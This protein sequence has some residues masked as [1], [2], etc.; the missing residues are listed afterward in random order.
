MNVSSENVEVLLSVVHSVNSLP[1]E[2]VKLVKSNSVEMVCVVCQELG[3]SVFGKTDEVT[4]EPCVFT[5]LRVPVV[6]VEI[7]VLVIGAVEMVCPVMVEVS[8]LLKL[9]IDDSEVCV[10]E[11]IVV[12]AE[13]MLVMVCIRDVISWLAM[14]SLVREKVVPWSRL[15]VGDVDFCVSEVPSERLRIVERM[16]DALVSPECAECV[17]NELWPCSSL[18]SVD[19]VPTTAVSDAGTACVDAKDVPCV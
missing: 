13:S 18:N 10:E 7:V 4:V 19:A 8:P 1:V 12:P 16:L 5:W 11:M 17:S 14:A 6:L 15:E 9:S 3:A 2:T